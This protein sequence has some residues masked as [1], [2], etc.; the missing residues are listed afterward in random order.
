MSTTAA[1]LRTPQPMPPSA[2]LRCV[3]EAYLA[4]AAGDISRAEAALKRG[5]GAEDTTEVPTPNGLAVVPPR[6]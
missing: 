2:R 1:R 4:L 5:Y 6:E 3:Q